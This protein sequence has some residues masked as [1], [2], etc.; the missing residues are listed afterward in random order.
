MKFMVSLLALMIFVVQPSTGSL[1]MSS[2]FDPSA[3]STNPESLRADAKHIVGYWEQRLAD[4]LKLHKDGMISEG[5]V[6][7]VRFELATTRHDLASMSN[8]HEQMREQLTLI[9]NIRNAELKRAQ[10]QSPH[11]TTSIVEFEQALRRHA[12]ARARLAWEEERF[13]DACK[14]LQQII[15][16]CKVDL[17]RQVKFTRRNAGAE[18]YV[19]LARRRLAVAEYQLAMAETKHFGQLQGQIA[20]V[21]PSQALHPWGIVTQLSV[22]H[23]VLEPNRI[24][25]SQECMVEQV[26]III[27]LQK[28]I[29]QREIR[30]YNINALGQEAV[31]KC[32]LDLVWSQERLA[33]VEQKPQEVLRL[34]EKLVPAMEHWA[35]L[36][37]LFPDDVMHRQFALISAR[38]E[39]ALAIEGVGIYQ[40]RLG[41]LRDL[42]D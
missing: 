33:R 31:E 1:G 16:L 27:E 37:G 38:Y 9:V 18:L 25:L 10:G 6:D 17:K 28:K 5:D 30:L 19:E 34:L 14:Q 36:E 32:I 22:S 4:A 41:G 23:V 3:R 20:Q 13:G 7:K 24:A 15:R 35:T 29:L 8:D 26:R 21:I 2:A 39:L 12:N 40:P 11:E 42:D